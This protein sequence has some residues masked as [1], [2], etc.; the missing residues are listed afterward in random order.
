MSAAS[1]HQ[2]TRWVELGQQGLAEM[3]RW[4]ASNADSPYLAAVD[5]IVAATEAQLAAL[6]IVQ[7]R[8][9]QV[10]LVEKRV[11]LQAAIDAID[12]ELGR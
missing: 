10:V 2:V 1:L 8:L 5:Q 9:Q 11:E 12:V 6:L 7:K 3:E 4:V